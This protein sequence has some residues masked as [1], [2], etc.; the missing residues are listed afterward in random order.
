MAPRHMGQGSQLVYISQLFNWKV[1]NLPH[2][3]RMAVISAC[4]VGSLVE[5]T[6]FVPSPTIFPSLT[7]T[8]PKGPPLPEFTFSIASWIARAIK[9]FCIGLLCRRQQGA[10]NQFEAEGIISVIG[11]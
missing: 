8:A 5:V 11:A 9:V 4:A 6:T 10:A 2:A 3:C 1:C 7:I